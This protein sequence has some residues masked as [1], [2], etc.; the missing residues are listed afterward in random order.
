MTPEQVKEYVYS[1]SQNDFIYIEFSYKQLRRT[2]DWYDEQCRGL[3]GDLKMIKR[4]IH[5]EWS[6]SSDSSPF[7]EE[8]LDQVIQFQRDHINERLLMSKYVLYEYEELDPTENYVVSCDVSG[9]LARDNSCVVV[10][11]P[12]DLRT[13]AVFKN[14]KIDTPDLEKLIETYD[15]LFPES[16]YI[17]ERNSYGLAVIQHLQKG[18]CSDRIFYTEKVAGSSGKRTR[19]YGIDTSATSRDL[20]IQSLKILVREVPQSFV[21]KLIIGEIKTLVMKRRGKIEHAEGETDDGVMAKAFAAYARDEHP[22]M[23]ERFLK[24]RRVAVGAAIR[25]IADLNGRASKSKTTTSQGGAIRISQPKISPM[26]S[27]VLNANSRGST[28]EFQDSVSRIMAPKA[29][30]NRD[31]LGELRDARSKQADDII[32][33][34]EAKYGKD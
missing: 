20:M 34:L 6:T 21:S 18:R 13:V 8:E 19:I 32:S 3:E 24:R 10:S 23:F 9:G 29:K 7:E 14:N 5:C 15:E 1:N 12:S 27:V 16:F 4:E 28:F 31:Y 11:H 26:A 25:R 17:I 30:Q 22:K 33:E 2:A